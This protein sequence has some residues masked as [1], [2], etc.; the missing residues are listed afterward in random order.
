MP[1]DD[2][3]TG[4]RGFDARRERQPRNAAGDDANGRA[5]RRCKSERGRVDA[6]RIESWQR[7]SLERDEGVDHHVGECHAQRAADERE[8]QRFAQQRR[9]QAGARR[10]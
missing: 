2:A 10:A 8:H 4:P 3:W 5:Q 7:K 9:Q 1:G 6:D